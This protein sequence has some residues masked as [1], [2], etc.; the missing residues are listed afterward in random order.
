[1][2]LY[3][4]GFPYLNPP[5]IHRENHVASGYT[6][7]YFAPQLKSNVVFALKS[8]FAGAMELFANILLQSKQTTYGASSSPVL[9]NPNDSCMELE[10]ED[11][12]RSRMPVSVDSEISALLLTT[13]VFFSDPFLTNDPL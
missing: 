13:S 8:S 7:S 4:V 1:M 10:V 6:W 9:V 5:Q 2:F 12:A 3:H 11:I